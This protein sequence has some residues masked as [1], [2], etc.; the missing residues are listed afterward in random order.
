MSIAYNIK[1]LREIFDLT[2]ADLAEVAGV[3]K[4]AVSQWENGRA[5]PR[6]GAIERM[7][8]C[9]GLRKS[10]LI[11]ERGMDQIDPVT[12]KPRKPQGFPANAIPVRPSTTTAPLLGWVHAGSPEDERVLD[13]SVEMPSS[14]LSGHPNGFFLRVEGDCMNRQFPE[15]CYVFV[16]PDATPWNGCAVAAELPGYEGVL[17]SYFRGQ[18]SL[19]LCAD[20]FGEYEDIILTGDDPVRLIGVVV[21][22]Q[23]DKELEG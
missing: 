1:R 14:V 4:N 18:S 15:G 11:E 21:W 16:D 6:M 12:R 17:R 5:E 2:Q 8:A 3:T 22:F 19:M 20:S 9:Y 10:Y 7:A 23:A 13:E